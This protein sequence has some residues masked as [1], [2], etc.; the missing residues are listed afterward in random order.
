L[1]AQRSFPVTRRHLSA[2]L[3]TAALVLAVIAAP[4]AA[5]QPAPGAP[6]LT[7]EPAGVSS[8][9]GLDTQVTQQLTI[10]NAGDA[11]LRWQ[12][13]ED[14]DDPWRLP[15]RPTTAVAH[16]DVPEPGGMAR[17]ETFA[18]F[19]GRPGWTV[20]PELPETPD[21]TLTLTQS[22]SPTIVAG[23][24]VACSPNHGVSTTASG[25]L[26]HFTLDDYAIIGDLEVTAVSFG[27]E[28][29]LNTKPPRL[30][31][32][33]YTMVD[34]GG[35]LVYDNLS[36][37]GTADAPVTN[38]FMTIVQVPVSGT[39]PAGSTLVVEVEVP[40]LR[41]GGVFLGA[42]PDGQTAPSYLRAE[43]CGVPEPAP[44]AELG[45][46]K[47]QLLLNVTGVAEVPACQVPTG[48]PWAGATPL[49][50]EVPPGGE[51][52]I[53]VTFDSTGLADGETRAASLCLT[54][55]DPD[56]DRAFVA[57]PV[58]LRVDQRCD[59]TIVGVHPG[60]L[61]VTEGVTCLA[62]GVRVEGAVNALDGAGLIAGSVTVQ[63]PLSTFSATVA[64]LSFSQVIG[65]ISLRGTTG[66]VALSGTQIVGSVLVV[67]NR[68]G[69]VP[70]VVSGNVIVGSLF[71]TL[72]QPPPTDGGLPN[73]VLGGLKLDQ[74]ADL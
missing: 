7:V 13:R 41:P 65:P 15:V 62:P 42:N 55:N 27:V 36:R 19:R 25:Y 72:N 54:S 22:E 20:E 53:G 66:S 28:S 29:V 59:R 44:T 68:T 47:M 3:L 74:C 9:Q 33:L 56:P 51:Q 71:C 34:P 70:I 60:P 37:I 8:L 16:A 39:A 18:G 11:D 35:L 64:E 31:V 57:V 4:P 63:G 73:T 14:T 17:F 23:S 2:T 45:F 40:D 24:S 30:T 38:Q 12:V 61:T 1:Q 32:N 69:E 6:Q 50:G 26:R 21:G 46:P 49:A 5:A 67:D 48:T 10:G 43:A 58:A 52:V